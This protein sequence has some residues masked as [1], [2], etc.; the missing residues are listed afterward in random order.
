MEI[1]GIKQV[2][3]G[4]EAQIGVTNGSCKNVQGNLMC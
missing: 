3:D 1:Y 2:K 4:K